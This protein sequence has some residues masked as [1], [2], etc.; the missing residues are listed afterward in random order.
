MHARFKSDILSDDGG[1]FNLKAF[2][3]I[4]SMD[5]R[6]RP[7]GRLLTLDTQ[8]DSHGDVGPARPERSCASTVLL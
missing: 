7:V 1:C 4:L 3:F 2:S 8:R 5:V 6:M